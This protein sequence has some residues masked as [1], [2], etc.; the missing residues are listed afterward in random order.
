MIEFKT[1]KYKNFISTGSQFTTIFLNKSPTTLIVGENGAGKS[2]LLDAICFS[3]YGRGFRNIN[4]PTLVNS[5]NQKDCLVEIEFSIGNKHYKVQRGLKPNVFNIFCNNELIPQNASA[6]DYQ[7]HLEKNILKITFHSFTQIV[8]LGTA[9]FTPFMQLSAA[10]RRD[11]IEDILDIKIFSDMNTLLKER[12]AVLREKMQQLES[13]LKV[14]K[15]K[16]LL[17]QTFINTLEEKNKKRKDD[18]RKQMEAEQ[19]ELS[20][21]TSKLGRFN[22]LIAEI[23]NEIDE[24]GSSK[25]MVREKEKEKSKVSDLQSKIEEHLKFLS[26][27]ETCPVCTQVIDV[28]FK[29]S[30][31]ASHNEQ[32][33]KNEALIS[34]IEFDIKLLKSE[35]AV[36]KELT[37]KLQQYNAQLIELNTK[38]TSIQ[39]T[40]EYLQKE[41]DTVSDHDITREKARLK[42]MALEVVTLSKTKSTLNE[43]KQYQE[44]CEVLLKDTGIKTTVIRQY[45]PVINK[46]I[47]KYLQVMDF[48]V[49]FELD[50]A[51]NESIKSRYRDE[52]SYAS[53]S[54]GEK[55]RINLAL[56]FTWRQ[57]AKMKNSVNTNLLILDEVF[58][59]SLDNNGMDYV[60]Q[61]LDVLSENTNI[62]VISHKTDTLADKF[63]S[64][65]RIEKVSN[66]SVIRGN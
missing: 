59:S 8:I 37:A 6:K 16:T 57:V 54:E 52:F 50:D 61:L 24:L 55:Q 5:I 38:K 56:L 17:Q 12:K 19:A 10:M 30:H 32:H 20:H 65:I 66:F 39:K 60:L 53:F 14:S 31:I 63:R 42:E 33:K 58:D 21:V 13:T 46:L 27:H 15:E 45:L 36:A 51:F 48:F 29:E 1:V 62:F 22:A 44:V 18:V 25:D 9:S 43:E 35:V 40:I 2:T 23:E 41:L 4:K 7:D 47:N 11:V 64:Q 3:L 34:A 28:E 26:S 49:H